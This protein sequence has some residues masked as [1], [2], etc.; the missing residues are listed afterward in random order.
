MMRQ[1]RREASALLADY[2]TVRKPALRRARSCDWL[3]AS[4]I[5]QLLAGD[6]LLD[7]LLAVE[8]HGWRA[9]INQGWLLLDGEIPAPHIMALPPLEGEVGCVLSLLMR[10]PDE[11]QDQAAVRAV[12]KAAE[13]GRSALERVC[14]ALHHDLAARLR[15]HEALPSL[16]LPY[17][18]QAAEMWIT[19]ERAE[20]E[21]C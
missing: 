9:Q 16:L 5:P 8:A 18:A 21:L 3:L 11:E 2:P 12:V 1:L 19:K 6:L 13:Q 7:L 4:D 14:A 15:R 20:M 10:H 17:V